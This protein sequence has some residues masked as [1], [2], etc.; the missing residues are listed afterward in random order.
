MSVESNTTWT[1]S[2]DAVWLTPV[3][4]SGSMD[5][6][7]EVRA[8]ANLMVSTRAATITVTAGSVIEELRFAQAAASPVVPAAPSLMVAPSAASPTTAM[9]VSWSAPSNGGSPITGYVLEY[10]TNGSTFMSL[11]D[12]DGSSLSYMHEGLSPGT[13]YDYQVAA[14]N[15]VGQ[16]AYSRESA[17]TEAEELTLSSSDLNLSSGADSKTVSVESN[18][19]WTVVSAAVWLTPIPSSGSMDANFEVRATANLMVSTRAATITVTAGSVIEELRFAQAAASPVVP[20]APS[21]MVAVSAASPTTAMDVSWS[22]PSNG[23]SPITGYVL[24]YST[25]GS[26]FMSLIDYDGSSLSYMHEGSKPRHDVR[27]PGGSYQ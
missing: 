11:I 12:Y 14:I 4:S 22:A 25:N 16:G 8:T 17:G 27:L 26:T 24:E 21:L 7:F 5:A 3:P 19:T 15:N 13:M 23:G 6:N 20:A 18:T 9:D 2:S 1:V 10:S